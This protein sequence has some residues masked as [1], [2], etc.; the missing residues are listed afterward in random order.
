MNVVKSQT[1]V[2]GLENFKLFTRKTFTTELS[3]LCLN[4]Y[5]TLFSV[6]PKF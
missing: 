6:I 2:I 5:S 3:S 4:L 1:T